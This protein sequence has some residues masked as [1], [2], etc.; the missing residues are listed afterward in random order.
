MSDMQRGNTK[1]GPRLDEQIVDH[2]PEAE[3]LARAALLTG[4]EV[5]VAE[6]DQD[7]AEARGDRGP[8]EPVAVLRWPEE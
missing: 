8:R 1:H 5:V 6:D 2:L 7:E 4:A 3:A